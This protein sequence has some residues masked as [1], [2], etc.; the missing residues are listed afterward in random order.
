MQTDLAPDL[1]V[2]S[3]GVASQPAFKTHSQ[4]ET[5]GPPS[6]KP[7]DV[8]AAPL[9]HNTPV[10]PLTLCL[11]RVQELGVSASHKGTSASFFLSGPSERSRTRT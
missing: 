4:A 8:P 10:L 2:A 5:A 6:A 11:F 1:L 3:S 9:D 7:C